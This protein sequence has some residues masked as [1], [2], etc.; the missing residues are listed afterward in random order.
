[1]E[2]IRSTFDC[3]SMNT[4]WFP[5]IAVFVNTCRRCKFEIRISILW[6]DAMRCGFVV[7]VREAV[8]MRIV[9]D[10]RQNGAVCFLPKRTQYVSRFRLAFSYLL[11][12]SATS[13]AQLKEK[14]IFPRKSV[15]VFVNCL[16]RIPLRHP[17]E[18]C[19]WSLVKDTMSWSFKNCYDLSLCLRMVDIFGFSFN[20]PTEAL[21]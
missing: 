1:M 18:K 11:L 17:P 4:S 14:R 12:E 2:T 19:F 7:E 9:I 16:S 21:C 3:M 15:Q 5:L 13:A 20:V 6:C 10:I 8:S